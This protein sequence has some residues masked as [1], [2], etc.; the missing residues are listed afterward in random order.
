VASR[1]ARSE[2]NG[3]SILARPWCIRIGF[4]QQFIGHASV[5]ITLDTFSHVLPG[6]DD[7]LAKAMRDALR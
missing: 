5:T 3:E 2:S 7:G 4:V 1:H 6:M